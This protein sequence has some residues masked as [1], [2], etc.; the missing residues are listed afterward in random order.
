MNI[1]ELAVGG[2]GAETAKRTDADASVLF[3][4]AAVSP[5]RILRKALY[6]GSVICTW[7]LM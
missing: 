2:A 5:H 1:D 7:L 4:R 6:C 3:S